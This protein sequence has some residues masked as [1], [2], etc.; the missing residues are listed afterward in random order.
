[1]LAHFFVAFILMRFPDVSNHLH[2]KFDLMLAV[3]LVQFF[4]DS[5]IFCH[6]DVS[7][8]KKKPQLAGIFREL[9]DQFILPYYNPYP[10]LN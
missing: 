4:F 5:H 2:R 6:F 1:M 8:K 7:E 9:S 3:V 10:T